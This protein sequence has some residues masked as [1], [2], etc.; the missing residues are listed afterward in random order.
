M[1]SV[2]QDPYQ[3]LG[4]SRTASAAEIKAAYR[5]LV[6]RHH[7]DAGGDDDTILALNA[8]WEVLGDGERRR[9]HDRRQRESRAAGQAGRSSTAAA[10]TTSRASEDQLLDWLRRVYAPIDRL[11]ARITAAIPSRL[12]ELAADPYDDRLME[13]FCAGLADAQRQME[14]V[15]SLFRSL[16]CPAS[17]NG[18]GLSLYH[19]LGQV[20]DGLAELERYSL[21]YVDDYLHDGRQMLREAEARRQRLAAERRRLDG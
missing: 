12:Q 19:C 6:K 8:A 1:S 11:L 4:V 9:A 10:A 5:L 21:G 20:Q 15:E 18:F 3:V 14:Q 2:L 7:P 16:P 17:A 13:S